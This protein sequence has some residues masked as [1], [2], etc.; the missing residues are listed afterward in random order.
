MG[1]FGKLCDLKSLL[2]GSSDSTSSRTCDPLCSVDETSSLE[3]EATYQPKTDLLKALAIF[4]VA[5]T[6]AVAINHEV[7]NSEE[8]GTESAKKLEAFHVFYY[9]CKKSC[10]PLVV[11][12]EGINLQCE[13]DL[14][15]AI[16]EN[17]LPV[18]ASMS[19]ATGRQQSSF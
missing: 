15:K 4:G 6:W 2:K 8:F 1:V 10:K 16:S 18:I 7:S 13:W 17:C 9:F 19:V 5:A 3:Y 14:V 11:L 12:L